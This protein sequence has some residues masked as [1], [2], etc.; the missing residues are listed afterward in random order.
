MMLRTQIELALKG[1]PDEQY[2]LGLRYY[3]GDEVIQDY[4]STVELMKKAADHGHKAAPF[5]LGMMYYTGRGVKKD[6]KKAHQ[7]FFQSGLRGNV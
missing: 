5:H 7:Y 6:I 3:Y 2:L 4:R 1:H